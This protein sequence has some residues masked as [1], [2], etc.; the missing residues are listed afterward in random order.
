MRKEKFSVK[1]KILAAYCL[2]KNVKEVTKDDACK[3]NRLNIA[4]GSIKDG[5]PHLISKE[6]VGRIDKLRRWNPTLRCSI[7]FGGEYSTPCRTE[8]G[9]ERI[10]QTLTDIAVRYRLDGIDIDWE[11]PCCGENGFVADPADRDNYTL[12]LASIR[13]AMDISGSGRRLLLT[14]A[15][16][17]GQY[18]IDST[19]MDQAE[20]Y[21]DC[22][23][24]MTYD[25]RGPFQV[26]TGHHTNLFQPIGDIFTD[27]V[28]SSAQ[29]FKKAGVPREKIV[30][31][32][33]FY[34]RIWK[35]VPNRY[36][37]YLQ[38]AKTRGEYGPHYDELCKKY[39]NKNGYIRYWDDVC[40]AP[41]LFNGS[42]FIS[43]DDEKSVAL[44]CAYARS[45]D[46][47]GVFYWEHG[48]DQTKT[49]L[50]TAWKNLFGS[51]E[52]RKVR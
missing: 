37:G 10:A 43:Y 27:S 13:Q 41:Y 11:Y 6:G 2:D 5:M 48:C 9:R 46:Y 22:I 30:L 7:C 44:K 31:G 50:G 39:V 25:M 29:M 35:N 32:M 12:L 17:A 49:L 21:L 36:N 45:K 24:L 8:D 16:G 3:L 47:G 51:E 34:S 28:A 14:S 23:Y 20:K 19:R 18:F 1:E 38:I 40:K 15:V 52:R 33:A 4:S 26:L 42:T